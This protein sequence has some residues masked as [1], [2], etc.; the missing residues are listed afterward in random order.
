MTMT[1]KMKFRISVLMY[2]VAAA[3]W[4]DSIESSWTL[5]AARHFS[6][7]IA[8]LWLSLLVVA[9]IWFAEKSAPKI[10]L[11]LAKLWIESEGFVFTKESQ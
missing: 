9:S 5:A 6:N 11:S 3:I 7:A 1:P 8:N 2:L 4:L 10:V